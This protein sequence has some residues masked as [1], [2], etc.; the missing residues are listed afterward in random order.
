[1]ALHAPWLWARLAICAPHPCLLL[2]SSQRSNGGQ[3][4]PAPAQRTSR[5]GQVCGE[6]TAVR[7]DLEIWKGYLSR[8]YSCGTCSQPAGAAGQKHRIQ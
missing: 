8:L 5:E 2:P 7:L 6:P 4:R 3:S 1:M